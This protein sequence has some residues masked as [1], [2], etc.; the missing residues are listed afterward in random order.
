MQLM[1]FALAVSR[2][3]LECV[4][5]WPEIHYVAQAQIWGLKLQILLPQPAKFW[6]YRCVPPAPISFKL[7]VTNMK[8][9]THE[10]EIETEDSLKSA[11]F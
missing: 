6:D 4:P 9:E 10:K 5:Y 11:C 2:L 3:D 1:H 8:Q 7:I